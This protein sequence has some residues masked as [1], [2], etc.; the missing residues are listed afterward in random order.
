MTTAVPPRVVLSSLDAAT[1]AAAVESCRSWRQVLRALGLA[2]HRHVTHLRSLCEQWGVA[3]EHLA[4]HAPPDQQLRDVIAGASSWTEVMSRLGYA[5]TSGS[6]RLMLRRHARR[7][8]LDVQHL[9]ADPEPVEK[10]LSVK[11][12]LRHLRAAGPYIVA[13]AFTLAGYRIS[14]PLEPAVY[15]L[16]VDTGDRLLRV[17]VKT[18]THWVGGSW[19]CAI[20][21]SEYADVPGGKRKVCYSSD[22]IDVFAIVDG[23]EQV[24]VIPVD[25]IAG[26]TNLTLRRYLAYRI[27]RSFDDSSGTRLPQQHEGPA[28]G[29]GPSCLGSG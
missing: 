27:P 29:A 11:P 26:M 13:G 17:Q 8:R 21:R 25:D 1:L 18:S 22:Q 19:Q 6:A 12:D 28:S 3:Y 16:V 10:G 14:W 7:L 24:Y 15:D 5:D 9:T 4:H 2:S 20:T 23:E